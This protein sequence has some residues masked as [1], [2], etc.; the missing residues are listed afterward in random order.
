MANTGW[1]QH[2]THILRICQVYGSLSTGNDKN[3][4]TKEMNKRAHIKKNVR[5]IQPLKDNDNNALDEKAS[6]VFYRKLRTS[7]FAPH[8]KRSSVQLVW[9]FFTAKNSGVSFISVL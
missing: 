1:I 4:R 5:I 3:W 8:L 9:S 6:T 7:L 2:E